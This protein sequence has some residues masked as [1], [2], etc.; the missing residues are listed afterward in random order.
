MK[1]REWSLFQ[2]GGSR[3][4]L[5]SLRAHPPSI[6]LNRVL[7]LF[8][9]L[10]LFLSPLCPRLFSGERQALSPPDTTSTDQCWPSL[11]H[12]S[13]THTNCRHGLKT[14]AFSHVNPCLSICLRL[15][16]SVSPITI[17]AF[18]SVSVCLTTDHLCARFCLLRFL[19]PSWYTSV[20]ISSMFGCLSVLHCCL[21]PFDCLVWMSLYSAIIL[22]EFFFA[23]SFHIFWLHGSYISAPNACLLSLPLLSF[24]F[25]WPTFLMEHLP[26]HTFPHSCPF[27]THLSIHT[28][29]PAYACVCVC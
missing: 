16:L 7:L 3:S 12:R 10:L 15:Y 18:L 25:C 21:L 23:S 5:P 2:R 11:L 28:C 26:T 8:F 24:S 27:L 9:L 6:Q 1:R 17:H 14:P 19:H 4:A 29:L 13:N 20:S 22:I